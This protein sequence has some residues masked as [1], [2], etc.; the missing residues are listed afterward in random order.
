MGE[1]KFFPDEDKINAQEFLD[2]FGKKLTKSPWENLNLNF[3]GEAQIALQDRQFQPLENALLMIGFEPSVPSDEL[4]LKLNNLRPFKNTI[5]GRL[6]NTEVQAGVIKL[7]VSEPGKDNP[8]V[9]LIQ[10]AHNPSDKIGPSGELEFYNEGIANVML[11][12][13]GSIYSLA[14]HSDGQYRLF[15]FGTPF[16]GK[17]GLEYPQNELKTLNKIREVTPD[18]RRMYPLMAKLAILSTAAADV[19]LN[20]SR[21]YDQAEKNLMIIKGE[22]KSYKITKGGIDSELAKKFHL[23]RNKHPLKDLVEEGLIPEESEVVVMEDYEGLL[24]TLGELGYPIPTL[25]RSHELGIYVSNNAPWEK[26]DESWGIRDVLDTRGVK[27]D[28]A[29]ILPTNWPKTYKYSWALPEAILKHNLLLQVYEEKLSR[30]A[31]EDFLDFGEEV[32]RQA[33]QLVSHTYLNVNIP[34]KNP[35]PPYSFDKYS[36]TEQNKLMAGFIAGIMTMPMDLFQYWY[37]PPLWGNGTE[38]WHWVPEGM[39]ELMQNRGFKVENIEKSKIYPP[40]VREV[41]KHGK[42]FKMPWR[43]ADDAG[44]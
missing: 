23:D 9:M 33:K 35:N 19:Y 26:S 20:R 18:V 16:S 22:V 37:G 10:Y 30:E 2:N 41:G 38:R 14:M 44:K 11:L 25:F 39:R 7:H 15:S 32:V 1:R 6:G 13:D 8:E 28:K 5:Y 12:P 34:D 29:T 40:H 4:H 17:V 27:I 31:K 43:Y 24:R 3:E 42:Y 21:N 36:K